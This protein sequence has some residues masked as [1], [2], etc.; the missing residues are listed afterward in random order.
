MS[1]RVFAVFTPLLLA[2]SVSAA[3]EDI[4]WLCDI[5]EALEI[6]A[7]DHRP[8]LVYVTMPDCVHCDRMDQRTFTDPQLAAEISET[9]VP[10]KIGAQHHAGFIKANQIKA[11]PTLL[12]VSPDKIE[13]DRIKGFQTSAQVHQRLNAARRMI[14]AEDEKTLRR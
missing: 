13:I 2:L 9:C 8:L 7:R 11:F 3:A 4:S 12:V 10:V 14:I 6:A 1:I 5:D